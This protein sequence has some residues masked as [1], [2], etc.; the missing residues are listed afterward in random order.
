[1]QR[2]TISLVV[3]F[4]SIFL[5]PSSDCSKILLISPLP[6]P[7][8]WLMFQDIIRE[9]LT[10]GHQLTTITSYKYNSL[11]NPNYTE[12]LIDPKYDYEKIC[13]QIFYSLQIN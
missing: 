12:V 7:S 11:S 10:R 3:I 8:H 9:L 2:E 13:K 1:M 4:L 5:L 6:A